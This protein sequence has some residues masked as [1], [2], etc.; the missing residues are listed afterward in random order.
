MLSRGL[1]D[2]LSF[3]PVVFWPLVFSSAWWGFLRICQLGTLRRGYSVL[4]RGSPAFL[5][6]WTYLIAGALF[7][8]AVHACML[9][10]VGAE[11]ALIGLLVFAL[12]WTALPALLDEFSP[13]VVLLP[14]V[15][16][17]FAAAF[18]V[19]LGLAEIRFLRVVNTEL[20]GLLTGV[21]VSL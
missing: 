3:W 7:E 9:W 11:Y 5:P 20:Y 19:L 10:L 4:D 8:I 18:L 14:V 2:V 16:V 17:F 1:W 13:A 15:H 12:G 6:A 21:P